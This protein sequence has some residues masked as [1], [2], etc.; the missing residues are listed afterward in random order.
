MFSTLVSMSGITAA[1]PLRVL[2][3][4]DQV[5]A[6]RRARLTCAAPGLPATPWWPYVA[7]VFSVLFIW[8]SRN[9]GE[10]AV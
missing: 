3:F 7:V 10:A 1:I 6:R 9:T 4:P 2:R 5:A 8:Y